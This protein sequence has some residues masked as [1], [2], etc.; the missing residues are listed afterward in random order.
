MDSTRILAAGLRPGV[1]LI[2]LT[3]RANKQAKQNRAPALLAA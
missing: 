1:A 2:A 3:A